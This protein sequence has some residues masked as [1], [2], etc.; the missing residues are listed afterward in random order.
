MAVPAT[1][2]LEWLSTSRESNMGRRSTEE[3][4]VGVPVL[5]DSPFLAPCCGI[6]IYAVDS[7]G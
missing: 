5:S 2:G 7:F 3:A 1:P 4:A 6:S